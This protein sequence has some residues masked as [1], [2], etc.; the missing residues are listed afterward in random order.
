M[1]NHART[2]IL[3]KLDGVAGLSSG[4]LGAELIDSTFAPLLLPEGLGKVRS[5]LLPDGINAYQTNCTLSYVM[6]LLHMPDLVTQT[7]LFDKRFTYDLSNDFTTQLRDQAITTDTWKTD[8][9]DLQLSTVYQSKTKMTQQGNVITW[10]LTRDPSMGQTMLL[11]RDNEAPQVIVPVIKNKKATVTLIADYLS[12]QIIAPSGALTGNLR[13]TVTFY[14]PVEADIGKWLS[15]FEYLSLQYGVNIVL[16][17]PW[18]PYAA[19]GNS[20][21]DVWLHNSESL[22]RTG[23]F[24]LGYVYQCERIRRGLYV[25]KASTLKR[26]R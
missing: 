20:L 25:Q 5:V 22:L 6:H 16:F 24:I 11:Q 13:Y 23:A 21:Q 14:A 2:L 4:T 15:D 26:I 9:C 8:T 7:L 10:V 19:V 3:N 18:E 17:D 1:I 12:V